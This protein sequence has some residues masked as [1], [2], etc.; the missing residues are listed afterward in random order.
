MFH[1][2]RT[3]IA[4]A[5]RLH[6]HSA[7]TRATT[8]LVGAR[9][10]AHTGAIAGT[11][12]GAVMLATGASALAQ[13]A[14]AVRFAVLMDPTIVDACG[15]CDCHADNLFVA[16]NA[17]AGAAQPIAAL[18]PAQLVALVSSGVTV[19]IPA[20]EQGSLLGR[21]STAEAEAFRAAV[22]GGGRVLV[23]GDR[24]ERDA[25]LIEFLAPGSHGTMSSSSALEFARAAAR[26]S[27]F[28][29][30]APS[31]AITDSEFPP[32]IHMLFPV[33]GWGTDE[34]VYGDP[35]SAIAAVRRA[36]SG[37]VGFVGY[38]FLNP[39][40][41]EV[42]P[43]VDLV[44]VTEAMAAHL[45]SYSA[46]ACAVVA[47]AGVAADP[48]ADSDGDGVVDGLDLC[49][50]L[51]GDADCSGCPPEVCADQPRDLSSVRG[52]LRTFPQRVAFGAL[53]A[54]QATDALGTVTVTAWA[55]A[56]LDLPTRYVDFS[57]EG[58]AAIRVPAFDTPGL[59][60]W[61]MAELQLA[62]AAFNALLASARAG[63]GR[64]DFT[65]TT[66]SSLFAGC[67]MQFFLQVQYHG[68]GQPARGSD[69][70]GDG[71]ALEND[72]CPTVVG[73]IVGG[74]MDSD[75]DGRAD[76]NDAYACD[77]TRLDV[78]VAMSPGEIV[79]FFTAADLLGASA[80][81]AGM[82]QPQICAIGDC[83]AKI[84]AGGIG[85]AFTITAMVTAPQIDAILGKVQ[86]GNA[87]VG[88]AEVTVDADAMVLAQLAEVAESI[89]CVAHV[90]N[91]TATAAHDPALIAAL[92]SKAAANQAT[93]LATGM[94][95]ARLRAALSGA[96]AV[97]VHGAVS[98]DAG[99]SAA[100]IT[101]LLVSL[102]QDGQTTLRVSIAGM[103]GAQVAAVDAGLAALAAA[104]GGV[105]PY[106]GNSGIDADGDGFVADACLDHLRDCDDGQ[107]LYADADGDGFGS[108]TPVPCGIPQKGDICPA[109]PLKLTPGYC[110]CG[111]PDLDADADGVAD[112]AE[113]F[114]HLT[115]EE[116]APP[117]RGQEYVVRVHASQALAAE[118][119]YTG[120]QLAMYYETDWLELV[121]I[122]PAPG[123]P[124][125]ME[126]RE[127]V[128]HAA[129][130]IRYATALAEDATPT[131][132]AIGLVDLV[133]ALR[134]A[135]AP[136]C[137]RASLLGFTQLGPFRSLLAV[138][139]A[140]V[141]TPVAVDL[142]NQDIDVLPPVL[143]GI[144]S[145][146]GEIPVDI[147]RRFGALVAAPTIGADDL[148]GGVRAVDLEVRYPDGSV[149]ST[150]PAGGVFPTGLTTLRWTAIDDSGNEAVAERTVLIGDYQLVDAEVVLSG[151][152][153]SLSNRN[154]CLI[155]SGDGEP[156]TVNV[157]VSFPKSVGAN[158]SRV[159]LPGLRIPPRAQQECISVKGIDHTLAAATAPVVGD[160]RYTMG[161]QLVQGDCDN[162]NTVDIYDF[163]IFAS[164]RST[165]ADPLRGRDSCA[166]FNADTFVN[167]TD[168][169]YISQ[170]FFMS[171]DA[172]VAGLGGAAAPAERVSVKELRRR[173]F[174]H[175]VGADL[176][177]DG[178]VDLRD[179]QLMMQGGAVQATDAH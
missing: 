69:S 130:R 145:N 124:L 150:W 40:C 47:D 131:G 138:D 46:G 20:Q 13:G 160:G 169:G 121:R 86:V 89:G 27:A 52:D 98:V 45:E 57:I 56:P 35:L 123:S 61:R 120:L 153:S 71:I 38:N 111:S 158:P 7:M 62:P 39:G 68:A 156:W 23:M 105:N 171:G 55:H 108:N 74:V 154:L 75:S 10:N 115:L 137:G 78:D 132:A 70:D 104:N 25:A 54:A 175:L 60:P 15:S 179:V 84:R 143:S 168:F 42:N 41:P 146:V 140:G 112:C 149:A 144:P 2:I 16:L 19:V 113:G 90:R 128:D 102:Q 139:N 173:G 51:A 159:V 34:V 21:L 85:G 122:D 53:P 9:F 126:I 80:D 37:V 177:R 67:S 119:V 31:L 32:Q 142:D 165:A 125:A 136:L 166:N 152:L 14:P 91:F 49:P 116:L 94:D 147:G 134:Q 148:C 79:E 155:G 172:C 95:A 101:E 24:T 97:R 127:Q 64:I 73:Q 93:I 106:C 162:N 170:A 109:D 164:L 141:V 129:G 48:C 81:C 161:I 114:V 174:G 133:F 3:A 100:E 65:A 167:N 178:W 50:R 36:G 163:T 58:G 72:L 5:S 22:H 33:A 30:T 96:S 59:C 76:R 117:T 110:G 176:N 103:S 88:G 82:S 118:Q 157:P 107:R 17:P 1:H 28:A 66:S 87:F 8:S 12:V 99:L 77:L 151:V 83:S 29:S 6:A 26:P 18:D 135:P 63:D 4:R 43:L 44:A 92:V 11:L